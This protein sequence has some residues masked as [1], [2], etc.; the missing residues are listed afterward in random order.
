MDSAGNNVLLVE[1]DP[2]VRLV[3]KRVLTRAGYEVFEAEDTN[4]ALQYCRQSQQPIQI[5]LIDLCIPTTS[6]PV[7]ARRLAN[8]YPDMKILFT[9]GY[10]DLRLDE[11]GIVISSQNCLYKPFLPNQLLEKLNEISSK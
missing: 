7:L 5:G 11:E 6:G 2:S 8:Q 4:Q 9:T 10:S 3:V 1:D